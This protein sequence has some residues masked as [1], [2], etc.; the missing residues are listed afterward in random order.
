GPDQAGTACAPVDRP[1]G[2]A[3]LTPLTC[4]ETRHMTADLGSVTVLVPGKLHQHAVSRI[5]DT[6]RLVCLDSIDPALVTAELKETVRAIAAAPAIDK[7]FIG[8]DFMRTLPNLEIVANFG[9]GYDG[10]D[11]AYAGKNGI[12]VTNTPDVLTEEVA[13]TAVGLL[14]STIREFS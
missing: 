8:P 7:A 4:L 13:D 1:A 14:I 11:A 9:V 10:V 3:P 5:G 12:M 6:F 2:R